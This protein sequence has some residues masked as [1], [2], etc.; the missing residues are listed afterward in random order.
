MLNPETK[1]TIRNVYRALSDA[2]PGFKPRQ[3]QLKLIAEIAKT[4]AGEHAPKPR[5][6]VAEAATGIGKSLAYLVSAIPYAQAN[7]KKLVISTATVAL[8]EQLVHKDLPFYATY[9]KLP[10]HYTLAKGRG[11]YCCAHKVAQS[12]ADEGQLALWEKPPQ[13]EDLA[14]ISRMNT[15]LQDGSWS[16]DRDSLPEPVPD[17]IWQQVVSE[18]HHC[19]ASLS[20]HRQC[21][22]QRARSDLLTHD[23]IVTNHSLLMADLDLGG[24]A[25]LPETENTLFVIDEAHHLP[26]V[27]R[28]FFAVQ[29]PLRQSGTWVEKL[30]QHAG[31]LLTILTTARAQ[32]LVNRLRSALTEIIPALRQLMQIIEQAETQFN[33][34]GIWRFPLG[35]VP[36]G[37]QP[38]FSDL[39]VQCKKAN[40]TL[41]IL[42]D[43]ATELVRN[44]ASLS[45][46]VEP[47]LAEFSPYLERTTLLDR[48]WTAMSKED[49]PADAPF[50]R[51]IATDTESHDIIVAVSPLESGGK[52]DAL[53]WSRCA[54]AVLCS[55]TLRALGKFDYF[56]RQAGLGKADDVTHLSLQ[57]PFDYKN[58]S[59]LLI[60]D[61]KIDPAD[62]QYTDT[63]IT[64][65]PTYLANQQAS[66]ILFASY[67]QMNRVAEG[68]RAQGFSLLVQGEASRDALLTLH[69]M[70]CDGKK[71][72]ILLG[73][74]SFS[75]GLDLPGDYLTNLVITKL[76]FAV[77]TSPLEQAYAEYITH[78]GGNPFLQIA[79][80]EASRK[81]IQSVGRLIRTEDDQGRVVL[82]DRRV[83]TRR[84][85]KALL[86]ALPPFHRHVEY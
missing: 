26:D 81:L 79:V 76:P 82:L 34:E 65:L 70:Q 40:Q 74:G 66:L 13:A 30:N 48:C 54:G 50:A 39:K 29:L 25:I 4:L 73:T 6:L 68:L 52:L 28:E 71:P 24:G 37:L 36:E 2:L 59:V 58:N 23:V 11:R 63:L 86:D 72:S 31:K 22:F 15:A 5:I 45:A 46:R 57:S 62:D 80:P 8:Q 20:Q 49:H 10:F 41:G 18:R 56:C 69:K 67:W 83:I 9:S 47:L 43:Q 78:K 33:A 51:W 19:N 21:P 27:A 84:Y 14:I 77:P 75:E 7:N 64:E 3:G 12:V 16:G 61:L 1:A 44:D 32:E 60:P 85:G 55:A 35:E 42:L 38:L 17:H 53:L